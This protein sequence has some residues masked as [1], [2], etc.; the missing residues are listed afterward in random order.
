MRTKLAALALAGSVLAGGI[1]ISA[2]GSVLWAG[3]PVGSESR[4]YLAPYSLGSPFYVACDFDNPS[5]P[6]VYTCQY[7]TGAGVPYLLVDSGEASA[8][9][10]PLDGPSA[11]VAGLGGLLDGTKA[12][13]DL[14][15]AGHT[16]RVP[17]VVVH[18][19]VPFIPLIG[20]S[21]LAY[22]GSTATFDLKTGAVDIEGAPLIQPTPAPELTASAGL[23]DWQQAWL[24]EHD[25]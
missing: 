14:T 10:I 5:G 9:G 11:Q 22:F 12:S 6:G 13:T 24:R 8:N 3:Q 1:G 4:S 16:A 17:V 19:A 21:I 20:P 7:D 2:P 25:Q 23:V 18:N 15:I